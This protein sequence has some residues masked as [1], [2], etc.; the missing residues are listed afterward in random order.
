MSTFLE[1]AQDLHREVGAA[2]MPP[3]SVTNQRGENQRL[4]RWVRNADQY[5]QTL[6]HNWKF[7]H[8]TFDVTTMADVHLIEPPGELNVWDEA[9]FR[10]EGYPIHVVEH[11][12]VKSDVL[13]T[14]SR[15]QPSRIIILNNNSLRL[16]PIPDRTYRLTADYFRVPVPLAADDDISAIPEPFHASVLLGRA[17]MLY[18]NFENAK[19]MKDQGL[20]LYTEFLGRLE[21]LQLPNTFNARYDSSNTHV[22]VIAS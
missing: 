9:T 18:G 22:E 16:D 4:V 8:A 13:D 7:L 20:E 10:L 15:T 19:E 21:S 12:S 14:D 11:N 1:L 3:S 5:I 17:M 6:W 2:G